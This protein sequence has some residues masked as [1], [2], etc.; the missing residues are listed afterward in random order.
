MIF[1]MEFDI[2]HN[3]NTPKSVSVQK[4]GNYLFDTAKITGSFLNPKKFFLTYMTSILSL[5]PYV[6]FRSFS[7]HSR[8][9]FVDTVSCRYAAPARPAPAR[10]RQRRRRLR[11]PPPARPAA[12][13]PPA[14]PRRAV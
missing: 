1:N 5:V 13:P 14:S 11:A 7:V 6:T 4:W 3:N 2:H 12:A 10:Q 8:S 9:F